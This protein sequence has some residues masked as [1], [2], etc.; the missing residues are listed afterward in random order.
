MPQPDSADLAALAEDVAREAGAL[1]AELRAGRRVPV[2]ATKSSPTD[3]VT[4]GDT[5]AEELVRTRLLAAR[6]DDAVLGEEGGGTAGTSGVRWVVDP[7][8]GTTNY[9][10]GFRP[11]AVSIA[12][13]LDGRVVAGCVH[14]PVSGETWTA[15]R[16]DGAR[17]D[18]GPVAVSGAERL[19]QAL[20]GTG[21]GY[22]A[23]R[24][25]HQA[26][27]LRGVLPAVRDIRRAGVAS[28][29]L[30]SVGCGRLDAYYE[31]GLQAWDL[32][33]GRLVAEEA[34]AR[35]GGLR[36]GAGGEEI[37]V[38][39]SPALFDALVAL[40]EDLDADSDG[41]VATG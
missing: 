41:A 17:L 21:F 4:V 28:I 22:A 39:A 18:G 33:A 32:A 25:A 38:A 15:V 37:L 8:D 27:V 11:W 16:G 29:D 24:R 10:Y 12:A 3:V 35:V 26:E 2:A 5:A 36:G 14:D 40:L 13:E 30:C 23:P 7:I 31:R 34:G 19:D 9:L 1:A 20:V 6:P